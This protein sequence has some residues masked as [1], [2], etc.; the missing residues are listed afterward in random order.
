MAL[1]KGQTENPVMA[2]RGPYNK[3][4]KPL[5]RYRVTQIKAWRIYRGHTIEEL[6]EM[7]GLSPGTIADLEKGVVGYS[8]ES[9][10][11][12]ADALKVTRG[13]LLDEPPPAQK[14]E[15]QKRLARVR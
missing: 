6:A 8:P 7:S 14:E 4:A 3:E 5:P 9:L 10:Q 11:A 2:K 15:T 13:Q 1:W 12:L